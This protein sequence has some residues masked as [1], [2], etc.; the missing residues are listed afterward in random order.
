MGRILLFILALSMVS[1]CGSDG[2]PFDSDEDEETS[3]TDDDDTTDDTTDDGSAIDSDRVLPTLIENTSD[4]EDD[5]SIARRETVDD[6][7]GGYATG[8]V[9]TN[10]DGVE[11][12]TV[13]G[14]AFDGDNTYDRGG[15]PGS[16]NN[17][18]SIGPYAVYESDEQTKDLV[19]GADVGTFTYRALYGQSTTGSTEFAIVRTGSYTSYGF[20]GYIY[21]RNNLDANGDQVSLVL[22]DDGDAQFEGDYGGIRIFNNVQGLNYVEGKATMYVDFKDFNDGAGVALYVT[23]RR[24]MD[25]DGNDITETYLTTLEEDAGDGISLINNTDDDGNRYL[26][27]IRP[28]IATDA[29]D[30]NGEIS[31]GVATV[32]EFDDGTTQTAGEGNYYAIMSGEGADMEI[33]GVLTVE[34][35]DPRA[36]GV[37]YQE[38]GGFIIYRQ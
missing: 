9:Y 30:E 23:D 32:A 20:G 21:Q 26:P 28:V 31:G 33:V 37:T 10:T 11:E 17:I 15:L 12:F 24:L 8:I 22:E 1:A 36:T 38:T 14:L 6:E 4:D 18:G 13:D 5:T 3:T 27:T 25:I 29:V 16:S 19:T 2:S 7:G 34:G 35:D